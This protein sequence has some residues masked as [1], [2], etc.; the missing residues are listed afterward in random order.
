V[1]ALACEAQHDTAGADESLARAI[2]VLADAG[3][4]HSLVI[5]GPALAVLLERQL[6]QGTGPAELVERALA[7]LEPEAADADA[8]AQPLTDRESQV[9]AYLPTMLSTPEIASELFVSTNTV[10]SH[11]KAI[12]LKLGVHQRTQAVSR[13]RQLQ[14]ID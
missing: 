13:A 8:A 2:G 6:R 3:M 9:L 14:L 11:M 1:E 7:A 10:R 5:Y 4:V 12:Y